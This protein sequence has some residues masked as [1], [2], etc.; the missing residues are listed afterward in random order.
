MDR[1]KM[2]NTVTEYGSVKTKKFFA[3]LLQPHT[4]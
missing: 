4:L 3:P 2:K 1:K